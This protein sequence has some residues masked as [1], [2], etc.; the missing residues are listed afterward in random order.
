MQRVRCYVRPVPEL[1]GLDMPDFLTGDLQQRIGRLK[2][3]FGPH[4]RHPSYSPNI[5]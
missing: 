3:S 2:K 4:F 1:S 5:F